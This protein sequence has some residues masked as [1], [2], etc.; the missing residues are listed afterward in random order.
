L[1]DKSIIN[2]RFVRIK[3]IQN[4]YAFYINQQANYQ[5]ALEAIK[6][7]FIPDIFASIPANKEQLL[8]E[9]KQ[10]T[11][12]FVA[13]ESNNQ[14]E[15][16]KQANYSLAAQE[17]AKKIWTNYQFSV[18]QDL[19][20][21]E[22]GWEAAID[23]IRGAYLL[24]IQL[25]IEW[26][27]M[28]QQQGQKS[29]QLSPGIINYPIRL[30]TIN[31]LEQLKADHT[32]L[33]LLQTYTI[34]WASYMDLV[35]RWYNQFVKNN[36]S[37]AGDLPVTE[38]SQ[39][40]AE[41]IKVL[42]NDIIFTQEDIQNFFSD[43]DLGWAEHKAVVKKLLHQLLD[44]LEIDAWIGEINKVNE[45]GKTSASFYNKLIG[46]FLEKDRAIEKLIQQYIKNWSID[47]TVPLDIIIIK[48]AL[49]EMQY[50]NSIP[51]NVAIN[52]YVDLAKKYSTTKSSQF[53]NGVL[54]TIAKMV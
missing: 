3:A 22:N 11:D 34:S 36:P 24:T 17:A 42:F 38:I 39:K 43:L 23:K 5:H 44:K 40:E 20:I 52:E 4:L 53:V 14:I 7:E 31:I 8:Q 26:F 49:C 29:K 48:L 2:R 54:D 32:F 30:A 37:L 16:N 12:I 50:F 18:T 41:V 9:E 19:K 21:L 27:S 6:A 28:A 45:L 25:I 13:W 35:A 15:L 46:T 47:R 33:K 10:A 51:I 1:I